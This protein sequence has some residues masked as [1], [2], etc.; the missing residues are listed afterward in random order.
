MRQ[1]FA[2]TKDEPRH[3]EE[4][5]WKKIGAATEVHT[6]RRGVH[7]TGQSTLRTSMF[8]KIPQKCFNMQ[9]AVKT[10]STYVYTSP[11]HSDVK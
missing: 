10:V 11:L 2:C 1:V 7:S 4:W 8:K 3:G 6:E 9:R 5:T